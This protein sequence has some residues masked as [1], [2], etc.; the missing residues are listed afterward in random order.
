M[1]NF[2]GENMDLDRLVNSALE[3]H[4]TKKSF[5]AIIYLCEL[6]E[7][8][9]KMNALSGLMRHLYWRE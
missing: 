4:K 3:L 7:P 2:E 6:Q 1:I 9:I 8:K 5:A